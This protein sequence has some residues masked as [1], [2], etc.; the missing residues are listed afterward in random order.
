MTARASIPAGPVGQQAPPAHAATRLTG[1]ILDR[2]VHN[3]G[4]GGSPNG[5]EPASQPED[6]T[7][8]RK[9]IQRRPHAPRAGLIGINRNE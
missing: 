5:D 2:I 6:N 3:V 7:E 9:C 4:K 8:I 1:A